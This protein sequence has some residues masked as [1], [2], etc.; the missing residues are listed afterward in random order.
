MPPS[1]RPRRAG[2][3][4]FFFFPLFLCFGFLC[5]FSCGSL[6]GRCRWPHA[7]V[8]AAH[9]VQID[10][11]TP[12]D[13]P[14]EDGSAGTRAR[15]RS[16]TSG[17]RS[18]PM[19][20][21]LAVPDAH[22]T[23]LPPR[24]RSRSMSGRSMRSEFLSVTP[25]SVAASFTS[26]G[27]LSFMGG[28]GDAEVPERRPAVITALNTEIDGLQA[29]LRGYKDR[30]Q[31]A[32]DEARCLRGDL[33]A[34]E[35][36][37]AARDET[38]AALRKQL[39]HALDAAASA[40]KLRDIT[41]Q[42]NN[43]TV[44]VSDTVPATGDHASELDDLRRQV[45]LQEATLCNAQEEAQRHQER[46]AVALRDLD[47]A[48]EQMNSIRDYFFGGQETFDVRQIREEHQLQQEEIEQYEA[49][50]AD[51]L[52]ELE[53]LRAQYYRS[54]TTQRFLDTALAEFEEENSKQLDEL[55]RLR[56]NLADAQRDAANKGRDLHAAQSRLVETE[57]QLQQVFVLIKIKGKGGE[58]QRERERERER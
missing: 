13:A 28:A 52:G 24:S 57:S 36:D 7:R 40:K 29:D 44:L 47:A 14:A 58:G 25:C 1:G 41:N 34:R 54:S 9:A 2:H 12:G 3:L 22:T 42:Q 17:G 19:R 31:H 35:R 8:A 4:S 32:E 6:P 48:H 45:K 50:L 18:P 15:A 49:L 27:A 23:P 46:L 33:K 10:A 16:F 30:L 39:K 43:S 53:F 51:A 26:P 21:T 55:Q 56:E 37:L 11:S 38:L 5:S 20:D